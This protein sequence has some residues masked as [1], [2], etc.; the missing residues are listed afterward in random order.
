[1]YIEELVCLLFNYS[2]S[3]MKFI[4]VSWL[5]RWKLLWFLWI[6]F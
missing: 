3:N 5:C 1:M 4:S 2:F 6:V